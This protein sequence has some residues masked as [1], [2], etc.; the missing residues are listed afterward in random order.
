MRITDLWACGPSAIQ[1]SL[2]RPNGVTD[3]KNR[4][5]IGRDRDKTRLFPNTQG[6]FGSAPLTINQ[7]QVKFAII[8][9]LPVS[10]QPISQP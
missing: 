1:S 4:S 2:K 3:A 5:R 7:F 9:V 10:F 6:E 8:A